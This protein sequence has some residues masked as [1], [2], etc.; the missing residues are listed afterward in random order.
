MHHLLHNIFSYWNKYALCHRLHCTVAYLPCFWLKNLIAS[1]KETVAEP[2][3]TLPRTQEPLRSQSEARNRNDSPAWEVV[4]IIA[5]SLAC[6]LG[7]VSGV[8]SAS[9]RDRRLLNEGSNYL[10]YIRLACWCIQVIYPRPTS[11]PINIVVIPC[12]AHPSDHPWD[13]VWVL[14]TNRFEEMVYILVC[15]CNLT[16]YPYTPPMPMGVVVISCVRPSVQL[17]MSVGFWFCGHIAWKKIYMLACWYIQMTYPQF[18][19]A[20]GYYCPTVHSSGHLGLGW[21][22]GWLLPSLHGRLLTTH[23]S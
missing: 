21:P 8:A 20:C 19:D 9:E 7:W 15:W 22:R 3:G 18:I 6:V 2:P 16:I 4:T 12:I 10:N 13:W 23:S 5:R 1:S 17:S 14:W 11:M